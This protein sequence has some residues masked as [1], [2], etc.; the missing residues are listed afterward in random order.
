MIP[1]NV[2]NKKLY[3]RAKAKAT[4]KFGTKSSAYRSMNIVKNYKEMGGTYSG[5]KPSG[6]LGRWNSEKWLA[7]IPYLDGKRVKCGATL[8][9]KVAC[10]PSLK[11][12]KSTP[13]TIQNVIKLHGKKKVRSLARAKG[14][15]MAL[16]V[17]WKKGTIK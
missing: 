13:I 15:N 8:N 7:V 1:S 11:K 6:G 17:N 12:S 2:V 9:K 3:V 10:R 4:R 5:K 16:R 14:K